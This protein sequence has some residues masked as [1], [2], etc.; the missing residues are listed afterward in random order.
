MK[1]DILYATQCLF[2]AG[3]GMAAVALTA[4]NPEPDES[5]LY[6]FTGQTITSFIEGD[7][8]L[9]SFAY[10]LRRV[11]YD[12]LLAAYGTYTCFAPTNEGVAAYCDSLYDDPE[13]VL[14]HNGMSERSVEGLSDSLCLDMVRYHLTSSIRSA[15]SLTGTGEVSTMLGY[16]FSYSA[17]PLGRPV[18]NGKAV[19]LSTDNEVTNG[20]VHVINNVIP[21]D[22]RLLGDVFERNPQYSIFCEAFRR[23]G[24]ADS[25]VVHTKG[26]FTFTQRPRENY[27]G[28]LYAQEE[29]R[30]GYTVFA[31]SN[32]VLARKGISSFEDLVR[33]ANEQYA[34]A[35]EWYDYAREN[36]IVIST[37]DDYTNRFNALNMFVAYHILYASMSEN[38][39][40]FEKGTSSFWNYAPD[41]DLYDYYE[42]MLPHTM[43]KVWMP[44]EY[45]TQRN[46]YINRYQ[47]NN[48]L[49]NEVG[50]QGTNHQLVRAGARVNR[51]EQLR[52]YNGYI[53][54]INDLLVYDRLVPRGVFN[55]RMRFNVT[56]ILPE[57]I[58]N[59]HRYDGAIT[60]PSGYDG[61][62]I[63][64]PA[65]YFD[66]VELYDEGICFAFAPHGAWRCYQAD[67]LQFWGRYDFA[68]KL[69]PVPTGT[70]E[71]RIVYPPL[72]YGSFMQYY[73]GNSRNV[74]SMEALG[75][76]QDIRIDAEDP[77]IGWT[78]PLD[79]EDQGIATD[80]AMRNRGY[81]RAPHSFCGH[82]ENGWKEET[83]CRNEGGYGTMIIR[84]ILGT[85]EIRQGEDTWMR[86]KS[87][88]PDNPNAISG[89]D[90][91]E[92][93][94]VGVVGNQEYSEDWY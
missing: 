61:S 76:P 52:A 22:T 80:V 37:G 65:H 14:P 1:K 58:T 31:E 33:F 26:S 73:M 21:R 89:I 49:T 13:A 11:R 8:S 5:D 25:V 60:I 72:S 24:L 70:Y 28:I 32:E 77:R 79:E 42:T 12:R 10:V 16:E 48:T 43:L 85:K 51:G 56:S 39:L 38:Q 50:T 91:I 53:I 29:C 18:F 62:R 40:V 55:E 71:V 66:N 81:M 23:T 82:G 3:M 54:S 20:V 41:A 19:A 68:F 90:F 86:I 94:P 46:L 64:V 36:G 4:C 84:A 59:R 27:S 92:L 47:T 69:P 88:N 87:L 30:V 67:Q 9:T 34:N 93:V 7:S 44:H 74:Q 78:S 35:A 2:V 45:I 63:G 17:D 57:L 15:V 6:T 83:S 75:L